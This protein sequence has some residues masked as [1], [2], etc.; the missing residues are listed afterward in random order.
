MGWSS[1]SCHIRNVAN[2]L[3]ELNKEGYQYNSLNMYPSAIFQA[4]EKVDGF[5]IGQNPMIT[6]LMKGIFHNR[7]PLPKYIS[8][9][10]VQKVLDHLNFMGDNEDISLKHLTFITTM[11]LALTRPSR[12]ADL[13]QL[14]LQTCQYQ[15]N[16]VTYLF[17]Y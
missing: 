1:L 2:F 11:L 13:P 15:P 4:H 14:D 5:S 9:C 8:M 12:S 3:A 7:P 6:Q 10:N 17:T 16:G